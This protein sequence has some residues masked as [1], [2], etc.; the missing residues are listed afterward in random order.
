M[1]IDHILHLNDIFPLLSLTP[2]PK[3]CV[4]RTLLCFFIFSQI[5]QGNTNQSTIV[6]NKFPQPIFAQYIRVHAEKWYIGVCL[7]VEFYGCAEGVST[8]LPPTTL[9]TPAICTEFRFV[10]VAVK[11]KSVTT[12]SMKKYFTT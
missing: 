2:F 7:R 11:M 8:T 4:V 9:K 10:N 3:H 12:H 6:T 5:F 1:Y